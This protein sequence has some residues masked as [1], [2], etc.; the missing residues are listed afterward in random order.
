MATQLAAL[1]H[2]KLQD[3][4]TLARLIAQTPRMLKAME[5]GR[6]QEVEAARLRQRSAEL[7]SRWHTIGVT[8]IGAAVGEWEERMLAAE[9]SVRRESRRRQEDGG[10]A[11]G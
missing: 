7:V 5:K 2:V 11:A 6:S 3:S 4:T 8:G 10:A 1:D 9:K